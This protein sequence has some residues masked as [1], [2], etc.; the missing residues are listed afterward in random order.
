MTSNHLRPPEFLMIPGP[1]PVPAQV[2]EAHARHPLGHRSQE[3]SEYLIESIKGLKWLAASDNEPLILTSSG[4][5]A[6]DAAIANTV[7]RGDKVLSLVCG[8]FGERFAKIAEAYG[9]SVERITVETGQPIE[10]EMVERH[11][12]QNKDIKAVT[13]THNETSTGVINDLKTIC[14]IIRKHG[15]LSLIDAV[16]SFGATPV[17]I[18]D[19]DLDIVITGSQKALMLP[20]GL[21]FIFLSKRAW[22]AYEENKNGK[23]YL[24][25]GRYLKSQ[26]SNTTPFTPNVSLVAALVA[27]LTLMK[28]T[29]KEKIFERHINLRNILRSAIGQMGLKLFVD[30]SCAS[31]TI[32]SIYPP[33]DVEVAEIRKRLKEDY[34]IIV[35]DGQEELQGKIFRIGHMGYVFERDLGMTIHALNS[36]L[37]KTGKHALSKQ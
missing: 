24:D 30:D 33:A 10:P 22:A 15:A 29:G 35:A 5:G 1:T 3:F 18:D 16:T 37:Q 9:A 19:W 26:A 27:S 21:S 25:L 32:T 31:P 6:M 4:T 11:L 28:E 2:L 20:P 14:A 34:R 17:E 13:I 36:I 12:A 23:F 8:V 7:N